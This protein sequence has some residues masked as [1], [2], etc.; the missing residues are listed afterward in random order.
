MGSDRQLF[1]GRFSDGAS[2]RSVE[3]HGEMRAHGIV[4]WPADA[5]VA[6][7][8]GPDPWEWDYGTLTT[9]AG[10]HAQDLDVVVHHPDMPGA[11]LFVE[12]RTFIRTLVA[13]AEHTSSSAWLWRFT[14][15]ALAI[16]AVLLTG[17]GLFYILDLSPA[18]TLARMM[19]QEMRAQIG[20]SLFTSL[21]KDKY[22]TCST[23]DGDAAV[24]V[25]YDRLKR[26]GDGV[27]SIRVIDW[28]LENA[29]AL[30]GGQIVLTRGLLQG[31]ESAEEVTGVLAHE[32]GHVV[33]LHPETGVVRAMG[34][35]VAAQ[36][37][38]AGGSETFGGIGTVLVALTFN[39]A[40]ERE[41]DDIGLKILKQSAVDPKPLAGFFTRMLKKHGFDGDKTLKKEKGE[42][43]S[44]FERRRKLQRGLAQSLEM[45]STHPPSEE[46]VKTINAAATYTPRPVLSD[47]QWKAL[48]AICK[49]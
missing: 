49:S 12:D 22:K 28:G 3:V 2:A 16:L 27:Q 46:R 20:D 15:P 39:R 10:L 34:L 35:T 43:D 32:I 5:E 33:K 9:S 7:A 31:A 21:T 8:A 18:K 40:A 48:K 24:A 38:F 19:P 25:L 17:A 30:P 41:A 36:F 47:A 4:F 11:T 6:S 26:D 42:T 14:K 13:K 44:A 29:F 45:F 37:I 23:T 1:S